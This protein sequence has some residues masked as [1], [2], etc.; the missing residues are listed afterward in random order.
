MNNES[1][2]RERTGKARGFRS[3]AQEA[4]IS[5]FR[6]ANLLEARF[7]SHLEPFD[8]TPP[9]YNVLRILRGAG[10][11]LP[12]MEISDRMVHRTP[13]I[14]R[15]I[16]RLEEAG[17]LRRER[18]SQDRRQVFCI[19]TEAGLKLL[20]QLDDS[21]DVLDESFLAGLTRAQQKTFLETL[22]LIQTKLK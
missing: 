12:T 21:V 2:V 17:L 22:E 20:R 8:L 10:E 15:L 18:S 4:V 9:Q 13:G 1:T 5:L 16:D 6:T 14:T 7:A 19:I 3:V 11:P